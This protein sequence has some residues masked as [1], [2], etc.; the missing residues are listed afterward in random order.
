MIEKRRQREG[1]KVN[2]KNK[3]KNKRKVLEKIIRTI[4]KGIFSVS[5]KWLISLTL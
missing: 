2:E 1:D 5:G 3:D 4:H